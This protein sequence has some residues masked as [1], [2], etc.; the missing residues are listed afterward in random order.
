MGVAA[1]KR[2][3]E[4]MTLTRIFAR[5]GLGLGLGGGTTLHLGAEWMLSTEEPMI[6][7]TLVGFTTMPFTLA[8]RDHALE[9][10][11]DRR[12]PPHPI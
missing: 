1:T 11:S 5:A 8:H 9:L 3:G 4:T 6:A 12:C 10:R 2:S 7:E